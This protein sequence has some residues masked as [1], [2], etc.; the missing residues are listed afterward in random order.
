[1]LSV[2][3]ADARAGP[4]LPKIVQGRA[5]AAHPEVRRVVKYLWVLVGLTLLWFLAVIIAVQVLSKK[6]VG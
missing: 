5:W 6:C 2:H 4:A 1:M 3:E